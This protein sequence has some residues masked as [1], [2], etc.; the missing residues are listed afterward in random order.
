[1]T[2]KNKPIV[3]LVNTQL[4]ENLGATARSMLNFEIDE[5]RVV[6]PKF[7]LDHEKIIPVSAG[8]EK[9]INKSRCFENIESAIDDINF[10]IACTARKRSSNKKCLNLNNSVK[11]LNIKIKE[12]N[13]VGIIFG[14]ENAGL[15]NKDLSLVDRIMLI[16]TNPRFSSLNLSHAVLIVCYELF[17]EENN[18]D[19]N[20]VNTN[21]S[22]IAKKRDL[23]NF[24]Y[25]LELLLEESGFIKTKERKLIIINKL[26]N[27]FNRMDL[28]KKE[29]DTLM[30]VINSLAKNK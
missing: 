18:I 6:N 21:V 8:A 29:L 10:L 27:I 19:K 30:G 17:K 2:L 9:V 26:R 7:S 28:S 1:M 23:L 15:T 20:Y 11:E 22:P 14:P 25:R 3:I 24:F 13:S 4:P 5:L 12:G 16:E